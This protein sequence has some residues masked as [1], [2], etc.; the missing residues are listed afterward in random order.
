MPNA[1]QR[2][3][4]MQKRAAKAAEAKPE[5]KPEVKAA[6]KPKA[7]AEDD[8]ISYIAKPPSIRSTI[9]EMINE[10]KSNPEIAQVLAE[11][12]PGTQ[13]ALKASKHISFYRSRMKKGAP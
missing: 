13:A 9:M 10:G 2:N 11:K 3:A 7:R 8:D 6:P 5:T 4:M 12:F 1:M